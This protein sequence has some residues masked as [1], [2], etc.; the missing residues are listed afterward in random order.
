MNSFLGLRNFQ[1]FLWIQRLR[2]MGCC[3]KALSKTVQALIITGI[4]LVVI[5][6]GI[7]IGIGFNKADSSHIIDG[8]ICKSFIIKVLVINFFVYISQR[9]GCGATRNTLLPNFSCLFYGL[10][11]DEISSL[12]NY[13]K[14]EFYSRQKNPVQIRKKF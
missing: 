14:L 3:W 13:F 7:G 8:P 10:F 6:I 9:Q 12:M 2:K 5:G 11:Q 1:H 4:V